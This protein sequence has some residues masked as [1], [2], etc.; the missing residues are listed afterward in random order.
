MSEVY[1]SSERGKSGGFLKQVVDRVGERL[2][3]L[4]RAEAIAVRCPLP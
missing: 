4:S 3:E 2:V 1:R